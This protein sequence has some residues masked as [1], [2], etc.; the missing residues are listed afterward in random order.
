MVFYHQQRWSSY[1]F[2]SNSENISIILLKILAK[3]SRHYTP[4][5]FQLYF[6][7]LSMHLNWNGKELFHFLTD[8]WAV[9]EISE[10]P[11]E[12]RRIMFL[13]FSFECWVLLYY[14]TY[15]LSILVNYGYTCSIVSSDNAL[16]AECVMF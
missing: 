7:F 2:P 9:H 5:T 6:C 13:F 1:S 15:F 12:F 14:V 3:A 8:A 4:R 16:Q 10:L 11:I